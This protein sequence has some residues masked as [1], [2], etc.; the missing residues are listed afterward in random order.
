MTTDQRCKVNMQL[1]LQMSNKTQMRKQCIEYRD[2]K[3]KNQQDKMS[4]RM[5]QAKMFDQLGTVYN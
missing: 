1:S 3:C 2:V 5:H 4:R